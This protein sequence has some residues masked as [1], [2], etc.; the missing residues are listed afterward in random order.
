MAD[1][2]DNKSLE[3]GLS[4]SLIA[5]IVVALAV[6]DF[7]A[8]NRNRITI[9]FLFFSFDAN[10]WT[11]LVITGVLAIVEAHGGTICIGDT[12]GGGAQFVFTLPVHRA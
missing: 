5:G 1:R 9:H 6:I 11:A 4:P 2:G 3:R 12:N 8:Q 7:V 10:V